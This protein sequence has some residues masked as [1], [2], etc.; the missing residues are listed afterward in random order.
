MN[1]VDFE[2]DFLLTGA[3]DQPLVIV[4]DDDDDDDEDSD[5]PATSDRS[6]S[7]M[8]VNDEEKP[9]TTTNKRLQTSVNDSKPLKKSKVY[10]SSLDSTQTIVLDSGV[11]QV[12]RKPVVPR[13]VR[14]TSASSA[15]KANKI[16]HGFYSHLY[17]IR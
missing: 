5:F 10:H 14:S 16:S 8:V 1:P 13:E 7:N 12:Q 17:V 3:L 9:A 6:S 11:V 15:M 2:I 4:L